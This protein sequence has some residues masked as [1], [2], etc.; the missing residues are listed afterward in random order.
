MR[1]LQVQSSSTII[2]RVTAARLM[3]V[4]QYLLEQ[5]GADVDDDTVAHTSPSSFGVSLSLFISLS[6]TLSGSKKVD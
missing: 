4:V 2:A 6:V 1:M 3:T 5:I